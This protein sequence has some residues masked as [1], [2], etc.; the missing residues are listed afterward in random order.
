MGFGEEI[1]TLGAYDLYSESIIEGKT[2]IEEIID[3]AGRVTVKRAVG[4]GRCFLSGGGRDSRG[5]CGR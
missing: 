4:D 5:E 1:K 2:V 3:G